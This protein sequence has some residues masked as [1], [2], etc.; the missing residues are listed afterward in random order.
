MPFLF[1]DTAAF[2]LFCHACIRLYERVIFLQIIKLHTAGSDYLLTRERVAEPTVFAS[3]LLD[4]RTGVGADGLLLLSSA[5]EADAT[6]RMFLAD[7]REVT[8]T[9]TALIAA[10]RA[11][12]EED[13]KA[14]VRLAFAGD[15]R[16]VQHSVLGGKVLCAWLTMPP[17][18][19]RPMEQLKYYHGI[20]GEV[21]R[22][23][24][25][26]PRVS[27]Y[28]LCGEH[29]VFL[30]ESPAMLRSLALTEV[31]G[32]LAEVLFWGEHIDLHF[33]A[34][35][36]ENSLAV[37]SFRC[38][39]G[40]LCATGEGAVLAAY[41]ATEAELCDAPR[42]MVKTLGGSFCVEL[43]DREAS[44]CAKCEMVFVGEAV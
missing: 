26:R 4:R 31:C 13:R 33:C 24:I 14:R 32:R 1:R 34:L 17:L 7:G 41:A 37:R 5:E 19:P 38:G 28:S 42:V 39:E 6:V 43:F 18:R 10:A 16:T 15:S 27:L 23:C 22:A 3:H 30:L 2:H 25:P 29:A 8:P 12:F 11:V 44:L 36:G 21:L 35:T 40:E 20:R 9:A